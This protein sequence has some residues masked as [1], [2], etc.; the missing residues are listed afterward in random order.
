MQ[1]RRIGDNKFCSPS[2]SLQ[3]PSLSHF[4]V[5]ELGEH[6]EATAGCNPDQPDS[7]TFPAPGWEQPLCPGPQGP[8]LGK[9][10]NMTGGSRGGQLSSLQ[11][12]Q[13]VPQVPSPIAHVQ[14][15]PRHSACHLASFPLGL[16]AHHGEGPCFIHFEFSQNTHHSSGSSEVPDRKESAVPSLEEVRN[17]LICL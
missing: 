1:R 3:L 11:G 6:R 4:K 14:S 7:L 12:D 5:L 17:E 8:S 16:W 2:P 13:Y 15:M 10:G 9:Q